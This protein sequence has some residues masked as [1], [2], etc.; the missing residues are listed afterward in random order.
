MS[1]GLVEQV[2]WKQKIKVNL[3]E[4]LSAAR[5]SINNKKHPGT[6]RVGKTD[7][8][9]LLRTIVGKLNFP[10]IQKLSRSF[11]LGGWEVLRN[12]GLKVIVQRKE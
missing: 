5:E 9:L 2:N 8:Y 12:R 10:P 1:H 6:M 11:Q 7:F 3:S 4:N